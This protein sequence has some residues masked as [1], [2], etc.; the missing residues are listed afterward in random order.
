[1]CIE[2]TIDKVIC[3]HD[4]RHI[5]RAGNNDIAGLEDADGDALAFADAV[6]FTLPRAECRTVA[7]TGW[8]RRVSSRIIE[9]LGVNALVER[10][11]EDAE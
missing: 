11:L 3:F 2:D 10:L 1:M 8:C 6:A 5:S 9:V 4:L 7:D